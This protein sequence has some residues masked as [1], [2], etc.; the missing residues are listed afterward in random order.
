MTNPP[1]E[2]IIE[3]QEGSRLILPAA[4]P[5]TLRQMYFFAVNVSGALEG[6]LVACINFLP[7]A[8][9]DINTRW[10][11]EDGVHELENEWRHFQAFLL[12]WLEEPQ[13]SSARST[14]LWY[15][16]FEL[17]LGKTYPRRKTPSI[18]IVRQLAWD[19]PL[20]PTHN[21]S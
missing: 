3:L 7:G 15:T 6:K 2:K 18:E 20:S 11:V 17:V 19:A 12:D 1:S 9:L 13:P 5:M 16:T 8:T 14:F 10:R 4:H 21:P